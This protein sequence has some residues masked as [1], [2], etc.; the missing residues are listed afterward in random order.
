MTTGIPQATS[1]CEGR[2]CEQE[3]TRAIALVSGRW[4]VPVLEAL[5]FA[6]G[7]LRFR[8]LQRQ[9]AGLS[10]K[11]LSRQLTRFVHHGIVQRRAELQNPARVDY[12]LTGRGRELLQRLDHIGRWIL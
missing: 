9:V 10:Q 3:I 1:Y 8:Q 5:V 2:S 12:A 6:P 7:P 11:E 4:A